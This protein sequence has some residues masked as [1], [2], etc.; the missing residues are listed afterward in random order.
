MLMVRWPD[1]ATLVNAFPKPGATDNLVDL[2][3]ELAVQGA[4]FTMR[5]ERKRKVGDTS[6]YNMLRIVGPPGSVVQIYRRLRAVAG[7]CLGTFVG[8]A[9]PNRPRVFQINEYGWDWHNKGYMYKPENVRCVDDTADPLDEKEMY[10][11]DEYTAEQT[12]PQDFRQAMQLTLPVGAIDVAQHTE[13][14]NSQ[15]KAFD[16]DDGVRP[17]PRVMAGPLNMLLQYLL[18]QARVYLAEA[19]ECCGKIPPKRWMNEQLDAAEARGSELI[20]LRGDEDLLAVSISTNMRRNKQCIAAQ[21]FNLVTSFVYFQHIRFVITTFGDDADDVNLLR[22]IFAP[23]I[24]WGILVLASAGAAG[25][26]ASQK[27]RYDMPEW[28]PSMPELITHPGEQMMPYCRYWHSSLCKNTSHVVA[29]YKFG[30]VANLFINTDCDNFW[31][32]PYLMS[33]WAHFRERKNEKGLCIMPYGNV[34][35]GTTGRMAYRPIDFWAIGGYDE[36]LGPSGGQD[37]QLKMRLGWYGLASGGTDHVCKVKNYQIVGGCL[38]NDFE[39][40]TMKHD[41]ALAKTVN[42]DPVELARFRGPEDKKWHKMNQ[43][44]WQKLIK[45]AARTKAFFANLHMEYGK[46]ELGCWW[47]CL[48]TC[49]EYPPD[50]IEGLPLSS[51]PF[52]PETSTASPGAASSDA[53]QTGTSTA[54]P[55]EPAPADSASTLA[56]NIAGLLV[57]SAEQPKLLVNIYIVGIARLHEFAR[58]EFTCSAIDGCVSVARA[59]HAWHTTWQVCVCQTIHI[60]CISFQHTFAFDNT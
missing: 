28:M 50:P 46:D 30:H 10:S 6:N 24:Q 27:G 36:S 53:V 17:V 41:R 55:I 19:P 18:R 45:P 1:Y 22:I 56:P 51:W 2:K 15:S 40:T 42:I 16:V 9:P 5:A 58:N 43:E 54:E 48:P 14:M 39:N 57:P 34:D 44:N 38:P 21:L 37:V 49:R 3:D 31:P 60:L 59:T 32:T 47:N 25:V 33:V 20:T 11:D 35:A 12:Q 26:A 29:K 4:E 8:L 52:E 23:V 13:E 7:R